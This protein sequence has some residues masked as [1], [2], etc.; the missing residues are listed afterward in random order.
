MFP[1]LSRFAE[2]KI[3]DYLKDIVPTILSRCDERTEENADIID[4]C[5]FIHAHFLFN[6]HIFVRFTS[7]WNHVF[8][9][10]REAR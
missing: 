1:F 3:G 2:T 10:S 5:K 4:A 9:M 7:V 6:E 8:A